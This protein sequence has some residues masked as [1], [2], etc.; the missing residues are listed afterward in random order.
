MI[1]ES[2]L[3]LSVNESEIRIAELIWKEQRSNSQESCQ[4]E[5]SA[6]PELCLSGQPSND[7]VGIVP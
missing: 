4:A 3:H 7:E 6:E 2:L 1:A 5:S